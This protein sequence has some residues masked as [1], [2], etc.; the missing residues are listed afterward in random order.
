MSTVLAAWR[1]D[2]TPSPPSGDGLRRGGS[3]CAS[4]VEPCSASVA[5]SPPVT[6]SQ[7]CVEV[8]GADLALVAGRGVAVLLE[9]ELA[10]LQPHVGAHA[11]FGV[12]LGQLEHRAVERR[13]SR[14][15]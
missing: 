13:G 6:V 7:H 10:L 1:A 8:A 9:L 4:S 15:G 12:A 5:L 11:L 2:V 3:N 14:P